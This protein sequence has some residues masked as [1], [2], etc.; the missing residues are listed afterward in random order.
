MEVKDIF[1][2]GKQ[3]RTEEAYAA[4][5]P[6]YAAHKGHYTTIAMFWVG[7]DMMQLR[8]QQRKLAEAYKIFQSLLRLY[9]TMDDKEL[10]GQ[11]AMMRAALLV[12]EHHPD[13]SMLEFITDWG[14]GKLSDEDWTIGNSNG[15]PVPSIAMRVVGKVFKEVEGKPTVDMALKAAPILAEALKHS[16]YNMNNQRYKAMI[17]KIMGKKDKAINIYRHLLRN[18]RQSYL[19]HELSELIEDRSCKIALLCKAIVNQRE[20]KYR[21]RMRFTLA[22]MLFRDNKPGAKYELEKCIAARKQAGYTITWEMQNLSASLKEVVAAS[23][24]AQRSF[25][26]EQERVVERLI[27]GS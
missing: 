20:E 1:E 25:Y 21:Q 14:I 17:Y 18:H 7:V 4:I 2:L 10:R 6:M 22:N 24:M 26:K 8:Y 23:D 13:F 3:G 16:P 9:P 5:R 19:Y 11:S 15:H 27:R 12:F